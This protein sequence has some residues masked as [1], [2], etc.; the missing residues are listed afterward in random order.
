MDAIF[1]NPHFTKA[2]E[3]FQPEMILAAILFIILCQIFRFLSKPLMSSVKI[4]CHVLERL[5]EDLINVVC[6][7]LLILNCS[8]VSLMRVSVKVLEHLLGVSCQLAFVLLAFF[9]AKVTYDDPEKMM[10]VLEFGFEKAV[11]L[12]ST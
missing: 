3:N 2:V 11:E 7:V 9:L 5:F 4:A 10:S 12:I 8:L 6:L 1:N